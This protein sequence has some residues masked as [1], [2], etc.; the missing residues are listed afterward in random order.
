MIDIIIEQDKFFD[1]EQLRA[2]K[3][4][5]IVLG[6]DWKGKSF[7]QLEECCKALGCKVHYLPYTKALSSTSIKN[8]IIR[9]AIPIIKAQTKR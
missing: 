4:D 3:I 7:P 5:I 1:I 2:Y 8:K 6:S 9:N